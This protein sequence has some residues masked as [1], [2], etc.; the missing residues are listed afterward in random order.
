MTKKTY[1]STAALWARFRFSVVGSLLSSPPAR[2]ELKAAIR[3]LAEKT[4]T[5]PVSGR[6][7]R[8]AAVTIEK[9]FYRARK[10]K[11]DPVGVLRRVRAAK[12]IDGERIEIN[13][14]VPS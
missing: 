3:T 13:D 1:G 8:F 6:D 7:V 11:D 9:W 5:H 4:W 2:G 14:G 10:E 12:V